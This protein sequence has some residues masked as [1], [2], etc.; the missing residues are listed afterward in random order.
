[1]TNALTME[2]DSPSRLDEALRWAERGFEVFPVKANAKTPP[3]VNWK[4]EKT[5]D[6]TQIRKWFKQHP[7]CNYGLCPGRDYAVVDLDVKDE[8]DGVEM[9]GL[10]ELEHGPADTFTVSTPSGGRHLYFKIKSPTGNANS[11]PDGIDVRGQ[12]GYVLGPGSVIDGKVYEGASEVAIVDTPNW[13]LPYFKPLADRKPMSVEPLVELDQPQ[14]VLKAKD[15]LLSTARAVEGQNGD[16]RTYEVAA[17][18]FDFGVSPDKCMALMA[19]HFNPRCE[20]PWTEAELE[21]KIGNAWRYRTRR[22]GVRACWLTEYEERHGSPSDDSFNEI[23][24][25]DDGD[26][27][28]RAILASDL[29]KLPDPSYLIDKV[30][31][32]ASVGMTYGPSGSLKTFMALDIALSGA[33]GI[34]YAASKDRKLEGFEI[35]NPIRTLFIAGE[36]ARGLKK[37]VQ[38]WTQRHGLETAPP[39]AILSH[40]PMLARFEQVEKLVRTIHAIGQDGHGPI[41]YVV[42]DTAMR[43]ATG[44]NL[45]QPSDSQILI[46]ACECIKRETGATVELIH[47]TGKDED[48]GALGAANLVAGV[49]YVRRVKK[50]GKS[51]DVQTV[52]VQFEKMKDDECPAP[53]SMIGTAENVGRDAKGQPVTSLVM[54]RTHYVAGADADEAAPRLKIAD[55]AVQVIDE[56]N[57]APIKLSDLAYEVARRDLDP[58]ATDGQVH[59]AARNFKEYIRKAIDKHP[60]LAARAYRDGEHKTASWAFQEPPQ[61]H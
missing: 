60:E 45:S 33:C 53:Y 16:E 1:M 32:E 10:L 11:F 4:D 37:R 55:L 52:N 51:A 40:M 50:A 49:D 47:H 5:T 13:M 41:N 54:E 46:D 8:S 56:A 38:A 21:S 23:P 3:L 57:R 29:H 36:G 7:D 27:T 24:S 18:V 19:E 43:A 58:D 31:P 12:G 34:P 35:E 28:F 9:F 59:A 17:Q 48:R 39:I 22:P 42:I 30:L 25:T 61:K 6:K 26:D 15:Y 44:L 2:P 14:N 20:P